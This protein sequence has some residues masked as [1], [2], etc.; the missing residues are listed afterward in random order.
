MNYMN[1]SRGNCSS[2]CNTPT[3]N[4][5]HPMDS[6]CN[7][8]NPRNCGSR[9]SDNSMN[10][11]CGNQSPCANSCDSN[12]NTAMNPRRN[13]MMNTRCG[14]NNSPM[15]NTRCGSNNNAMMNTRCNNRCNNNTSRC[16][17]CDP[18]SSSH[19]DPL[20]GMPIG[21]GYVPWQQWSKTYDYCEGLSRG[22][23]FPCLDLPFF[24]CI[25]RDFRCNKGG[26][27]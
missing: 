5:R 26:R 20:A 4:N 1:Q 21:I 10:S 12:N 2:Q 23:I 13:S 8:S 11:P 22:T 18:G 19:N 15:M 3:G 24:G 27:A 7:S 6:G 25:P 17:E 16:E 14:N 9:C